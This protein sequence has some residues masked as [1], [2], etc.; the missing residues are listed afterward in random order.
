MPPKVQLCLCKGHGCVDADRTSTITG[1]ILKGRYLGSEEFRT[2]QR[3]E[4][5]A[6]HSGHNL[7]QDAVEN[8]FKAKRPITLSPLS[9]SSLM[10]DPSKAALADTDADVLPGGPT[11][12]AE[13]QRPALDDEGNES[14]SNPAGAPTNV[15]ENQT[16]QAIES[17][18]VDFQSWLHADIGCDELVLEVTSSGEPPPHL[19]LRADV[20]SNSRFIQYE[21][22]MFDLL[23]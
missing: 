7:H 9:P 20:T 16:M 19:P 18:R 17:C 5:F 14:I 4:K 23:D 12:D 6:K 15:Q 21:A 2:H 22:M 8:S 10:L 3:E 1:Q 11:T 13:V